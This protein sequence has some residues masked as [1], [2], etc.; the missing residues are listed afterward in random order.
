VRQQ[1]SLSEPVRQ[2][3]RRLCMIAQVMIGRCRVAFLQ[4]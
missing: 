4:D 2:R 1:L 3:L